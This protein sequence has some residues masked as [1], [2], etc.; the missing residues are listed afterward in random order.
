MSL[1]PLSDLYGYILQVTEEI[2]AKTG[3]KY[4]DLILKTSKQEQETIRIM[5]KSNPAVRRNNFVTRKNKSVRLCNIFKSSG[6]SGDMHFYNS[7]RGSYFEESTVSFELHDYQTHSL[8]EIKNA[9]DGN[10]N[11]KGVFKW[12]TTETAKEKKDGTEGRLREAT[13]VDQN[14]ETFPISVWGDMIDSIVEDK[15]ILITRCQIKYYFGIKK[16]ATTKYSLLFI[17]EQKLDIDI[18]DIKTTDWQKLEEDEKKKSYPTVTKAVLIG[19]DVDIF[20]KCTRKTCAKKVNPPKEIFMPLLRSK[21]GPKNSCYWF[22]WE[23]G[24]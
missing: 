6:T 16:L 18:K 21:T 10:F 1:F 9:E 15:V 14:G 4:F 5:L 22:H 3:N 20:P 2:T 24:N 12:S 7:H 8:K 11:I 19:C 13:I 23:S 17:T